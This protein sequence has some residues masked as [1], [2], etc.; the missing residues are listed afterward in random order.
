MASKFFLRRQA[1]TTPISPTPDAGWEDSS[2]IVRCN[3]RLVTSGDSH[4]DVTITEAT[5]TDKDCAARQYVCVLAAG[6]TVTG[7]QAVQFVARFQETTTSNNM[8]S[9]FGIRVIASNGTTVRKTVLAVTREANEMVASP[10]ALTNRNN[11]ATSAATNYTTVDG[12]CLVVEIGA[13]GDPAGANPHTY[14]IGLGDN[15]AGFLAADDT[16]TTANNPW[17]Q[18][19]DTLTIYRHRLQADQGAFTAT[20]Q[21]AALMNPERFPIVVMSR[22]LR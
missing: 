11:T 12:D 17:C 19:A 14:A 13:G 8:H 15:A 10:T 5:S 18:L 22:I 20:G 3:L 9:V 4:A 21:G 7:S 6:Q 16:T 2:S 1:E